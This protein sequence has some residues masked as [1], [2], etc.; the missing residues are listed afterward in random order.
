MEEERFSVGIKILRMLENHN[1]ERKSKYETMVKTFFNFFEFIENEVT[2][3]DKFDFCPIYCL[4]KYLNNI[5]FAYIRSL[6]FIKKK[7]S[8]VRTPCL[9]KKKTFIK[10]NLYF[11]VL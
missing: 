9:V 1:L 7:G 5:F 2:N 8:S 11:S 3:F 10:P 4:L 6:F